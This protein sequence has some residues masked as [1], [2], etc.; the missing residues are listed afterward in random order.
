VDVHGA[1]NNFVIVVYPRCDT[2]PFKIRT[3]RRE[4]SVTKKAA[5]PKKK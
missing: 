4:A 3:W 1:P 2:N 5:A